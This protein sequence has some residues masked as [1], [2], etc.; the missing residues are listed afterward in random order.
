MYAPMIYNALCVM[1]LMRA[2]TLRW[3]VGGGCALEIESFLVLRGVGEHP[4]PHLELI[5]NQRETVRCIKDAPLLNIIDIP[6]R[7]SPY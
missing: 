4:P 6:D 7:T 3:H 1:F 2:D 5:R